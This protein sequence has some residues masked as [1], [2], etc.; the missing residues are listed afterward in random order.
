MPIQRRNSFSGF[1][2]SASAVDGPSKIAPCP[3]TN[4]K[5]AGTPAR[6]I[7]VGHSSENEAAL[8]LLPFQ[9][10][11]SSVQLP[12]NFLEYSKSHPDICRNDKVT[13]ISNTTWQKSPTPAHLPCA[14]IW[15]KENFSWMGPLGRHVRR[16]LD[17]SKRLVYRQLLRKRFYSPVRERLLALQKKNCQC[18][19]WKQPPL[20]LCENCR[21]MRLPHFLFCGIL[22]VDSELWT[23]IPQATRPECPFRQLITH[24]AKDILLNIRDYTNAQE[25]QLIVSYLIS[26]VPFSPFLV[27]YLENNIGRIDSYISFFSE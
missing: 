2:N 1:E 25:L 22:P 9:K 18:S 20:A 5:E 10:R 12:I 21:H 4:G 8:A 6:S 24:I 19:Q 27:L 3:I 11:R 14:E 13:I 15:R 17:F 16:L 7:Q 26:S 23:T